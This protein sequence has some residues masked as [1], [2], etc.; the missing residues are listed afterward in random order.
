MY[1]SFSQDATKLQPEVE[2]INNYELAVKHFFEAMQT[3]EEEILLMT[4]SGAAKKYFE[5]LEECRKERNVCKI[6][7]S[8][9]GKQL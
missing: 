5:V 9:S 8:N 1:L 2:V 3:A 4:C 6:N 7:G